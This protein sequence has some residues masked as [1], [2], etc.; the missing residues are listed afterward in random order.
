MFSGHFIS[1]VENVVLLAIYDALN[2]IIADPSTYD[3]KEVRPAGASNAGQERMI[4][5]VRGF[6]VIAYTENGVYPPKA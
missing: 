6:G 3:Y 2:E 4:K 5:F 1:I